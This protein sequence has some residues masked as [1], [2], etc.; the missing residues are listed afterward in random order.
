MFL[1][2]HTL[3]GEIHTKS[4]IGTIIVIYTKIYGSKKKEELNLDKGAEEK[5]VAGS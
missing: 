3:F 1:E 4:L 5:F 2:A